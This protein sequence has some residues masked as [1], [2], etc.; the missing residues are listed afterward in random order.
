MNSRWTWFTALR[1]LK[2]RRREK[3]H[4]ATFFAVSGIC[5]GLMTLITVISV[6]NGFQQGFIGS[7]NEIGSY[8]LQLEPPKRLSEETLRKI[9]AIPE[10]RA[11]VPFRESYGLIAEPEG[12]GGAPRGILLRGLGPS[13]L[14][15]RGFLERI[16][17]RS[18][19]FDLSDPNGIILGRAAAV[20]MGLRTGDEVSY[21]FFPNDS[22]SFS[23]PKRVSFRIKGIFSTEYYEYSASLG[24]T[25]LNA[26]IFRE[27]PGPEHY[28]LK[29]KNHFKD[30]EAAAA[31]KKIPALRNAEPRSWRVYNRSFFGALR[32]E[33]MTMM[34]LISLI[35]LVVALNIRQSLKRSIYERNEDIALLRSLGASA[36]AVRGIFVL[37]GFL[38]AAAGVL[39]GLTAG[40]FL[41]FHI[42]PILN[43]LYGSMQGLSGGRSRF[44][45]LNVPVAVMKQDLIFMVSVSLLTAIGAGYRAS[46]SVSAVSP[47]EI[48]RH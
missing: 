40:L 44:F 8:H 2:T 7:M 43:V 14:R 9:R 21:L 17:M 30:R 24:F 18:G 42:N 20:R 39:L 45:F 23:K 22:I 10:L 31:L 29:I 37:Q 6:M 13:V 32:T 28:G 34:V 41:T 33:K 5:I 4:V 27:M 46:A 38:I 3:G 16:H 25:A 35:F 36:G 11:V 12:R 15:D 26:P 19:R 47:Q 48:F 1:Y